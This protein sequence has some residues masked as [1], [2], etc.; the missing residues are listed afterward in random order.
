MLSCQEERLSKEGGSPNKAVITLGAR[1][2]PDTLDKVSKIS[3][4]YL[5]KERQNEGFVYNLQPLIT[6]SKHLVK[7][8][9]KSSFGVMGVV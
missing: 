5:L 4:Q 3:V 9:C 6:G 1:L 2:S 8:F 7:Y